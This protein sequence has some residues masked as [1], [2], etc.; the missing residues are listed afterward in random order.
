MSAPDGKLTARDWWSVG[1]PMPAEREPEW[2]ADLLAPTTTD[3]G[4]GHPMNGVAPWPT[5][6]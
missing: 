4:A 1:I 5:G 3:M 2:S 6:D